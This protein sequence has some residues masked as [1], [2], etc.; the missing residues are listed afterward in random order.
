MKRANNRKS[1]LPNN[2]SSAHLRYV[3]NSQ[4]ASILSDEESWDF[5]KLRFYLARKLKE[6]DIEII[7]L[8]GKCLYVK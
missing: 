4:L 7:Q 2:L 6:Q 3:N 8:I 5:S 1:V